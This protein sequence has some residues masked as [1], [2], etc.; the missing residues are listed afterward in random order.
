M[1]HKKG[2]TVLGPAEHPW[3]DPLWRRVALVVFCGGWTIVEF[4]AGNTG[5]ASIVG[6]ITAYA[7]WCYL[8]AY[9]GADDP[10]RKD[11][12]QANEDE[13]Q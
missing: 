11:P 10:S 13:A 1:T 4:A 7:A 9:K 12:A 5:W 8:Y 6:A 2:K 3:L